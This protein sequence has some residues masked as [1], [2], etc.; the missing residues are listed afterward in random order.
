[1]HFLFFYCFLCKRTVI[2][3]LQVLLFRAYQRH[4]LVQSQ[5]SHL[6][7]KH[8]KALFESYS[9]ANICV[10]CTH[11]YSCKLSYM[12]LEARE[13]FFVIP[14]SVLHIYLSVASSHWA[15]LVSRSDFKVGKCTK[16]HWETCPSKLK[17]A[18]LNKRRRVGGNLFRSKEKIFVSVWLMEEF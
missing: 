16:L 15:P 11:T 3:A 8:I 9:Q 13:S 10:F 14:F 7:Y 12:V 18:H 4:F 5:Q 17:G 6:K 2:T 1:M